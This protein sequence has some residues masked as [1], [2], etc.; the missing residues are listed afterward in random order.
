MGSGR[1]RTRHMGKGVKGDESVRSFSGFLLLAGPIPYSLRAERGAPPFPLRPRRKGG[2]SL[3]RPYS[4]VS[5]V[6]RVVVWNVCSAGSETSAWRWTCP[7]YKAALGVPK[8]MFMT[9]VPEA[10]ITPDA[11]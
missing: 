9:K 1:E 2:S 5:T 10:G 4:L 11:S 7:S 3:A 6:M 8:D